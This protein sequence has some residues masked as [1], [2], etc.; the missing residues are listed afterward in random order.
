MTQPQQ[1]REISHGEMALQLSFVPRS[2]GT[3]HEAGAEMVWVIREGCRRLFGGMP[4]APGILATG[5]S[6]RVALAA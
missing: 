4:P 3:A 2:T 5:Q 1:R 6:R